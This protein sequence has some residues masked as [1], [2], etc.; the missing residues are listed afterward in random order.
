MDR[1]YRTVPLNC[2]NRL[3][4]KVSAGGGV[5]GG[6]E[7][8]GR[9]RSSSCFM[10]P[11]LPFLRDDV[12]SRCT[13]CWML[14]RHPRADRKCLGAPIIFTTPSGPLMPCGNVACLNFSV[15][16]DSIMSEFVWLWPNTTLQV[17]ASFFLSFFLSF[18]FQE[19]AF[20]SFNLVSGM[21]CRGRGGVGRREGGREGGKFKGN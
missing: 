20:F 10:L 13:R 18:F 15:A 1:W 16:F 6:R 7:V 9:R 17:A 14:E 19:S 11:S 3:T 12:C 4:L 8:G 2:G 5:G 21:E